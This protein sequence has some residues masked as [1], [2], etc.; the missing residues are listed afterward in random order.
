MAI[1]WSW[2]SPLSSFIRLLQ[3]IFRGWN[4]A[5]LWDLSVTFSKYILPR[6]RRYR[7]MEKHGYPTMVI[8]K[9]DIKGCSDKKDL[10]YERKWDI[11]LDKMI[12][13][14]GLI[15]REEGSHSDNVDGCWFE[16]WQKAEEIRRDKIKE[17]LELFVKY[18]QCLWD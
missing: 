8:V 9:K 5:E 15:L 13:A 4:D 17:G 3:T 18:Y 12:I 14:F 16:N 1:Y 10:Y 2:K 7:K 11:I 6:L